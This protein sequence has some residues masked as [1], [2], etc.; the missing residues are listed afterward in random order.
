[1]DLKLG[2]YKRFETRGF[3]EGLKL[4]GLLKIILTN[5]LLLILF[6]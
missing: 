4:G 1:M 3:T 5:I 6:V 2:V